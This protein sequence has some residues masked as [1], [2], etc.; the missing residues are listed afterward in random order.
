MRFAV[1]AL[2]SVPDT[3]TTRRLF[4]L[5]DLD[6]R[7]VAKVLFHRRKQQ[8]GSSEEL[9]WDQ[10]AIA[11][12][13]LIQHSVDDVSVESLHLDTHS[14]AEML[15]AFYRVMLRYGSLIS[16]DGGRQSLPLLHFRT[17]MHD[18]SYPA[19]W[20]ALRERSDLH[21]DISDWLSPVPDDR[22]SLD[23]T[24]RRL[25]LPGLLGHDEGS[26]VD[27]WLQGR[28]EGI[29]AFSDIAA[30][31]TYLLALRL[32]VTTGEVARHDSARV[33]ARLRE[34]LAG[35]GSRHLTDFLAAWG[36]D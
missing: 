27:A 24:A 3:A 5:H 11:G 14:E 25:G 26:V 30:L 22:P 15:H 12:I 36:E 28:P 9:R 8:T 10:R 33:R 4:E 16:W 17:L 29:H 1:L 13:T 20:Q 21:L 32:F 35:A 7:S 6:D 34:L 23:R 31:N 19:Y 2:A 18:V